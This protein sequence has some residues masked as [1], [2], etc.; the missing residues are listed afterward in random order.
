LTGGD[1]AGR[2][3]VAG[4]GVTEQGVRLGRSPRDLR[5]EALELALADAGLV[6][7]DVDGYIGTSSEMFDYPRRRPLTAQDLDGGAPMT[8]LPGNAERLFGFTPLEPA[9]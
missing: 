3:A 5:R 7:R 2:F 9:E 1:F 4:L 6:R 8:N